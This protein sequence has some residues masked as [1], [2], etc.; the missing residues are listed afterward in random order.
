MS[1]YITLPEMMK[2]Y[3]STMQKYQ[4]YSKLKTIRKNKLVPDDAII[5]DTAHQRTLVNMAYIDTIRQYVLQ[6]RITAG[7]VIQHADRETWIGSHRLQTWYNIDLTREEIDTQLFK[8]HQD[9]ILPENAFNI[10]NNRRA[11]GISIHCDFVDEFIKKMELPV[12]DGTLRKDWITAS[13]LM[14]CFSDGIEL[15]IAMRETMQSIK[16]SNL[17]PSDAFI[18][19]P[20]KRHGA[21]L[22]LNKKYLKD[23]TSIINHG[24]IKNGARWLFPI[25]LKM[26]HKIPT[27]H[28]TLVP[29]LQNAAANELLPFGA[30]TMLGDMPLLNGFYLAE[31]CAKIDIL[32]EQLKNVRKNALSPTQIREQYR[33]KIGAT[34]IRNGMIEA[35]NQYIL[36]SDAIIKINDRVYIDKDYA[37]DFVQ[38]LTSILG[39]SGHIR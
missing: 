3:F 12:L 29:T 2:K 1:Q 20:S 6:K 22:L 33:V 28:K 38:Q 30:V 18:E 32:E 35:V 9:K 15:S 8:A 27:C 13:H 10:T 16:K 34:T 39:S 26:N 7:T 11:R 14:S 25:T 36:P 23:F 5:F 17:L 24:F 4:V 21:Q 31:F 19:M 37:D